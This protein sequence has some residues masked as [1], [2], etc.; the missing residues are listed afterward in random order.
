MWQLKWPGCRH[1][2]ASLASRPPCW[3]PLDGDA[4]DDGNAYGSAVSAAACREILWPVVI[5]KPDG[6]DEF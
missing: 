5:V 6:T 1:R 3:D 4:L 2:M